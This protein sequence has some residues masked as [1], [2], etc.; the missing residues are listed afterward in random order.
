MSFLEDPNLFPL[1][2]Q[3]HR[4]HWSTH[5]SNSHR[6]QKV[7]QVLDDIAIIAPE[8]GIIRGLLQGIPF[9]TERPW[10]KPIGYHVI[11]GKSP[12][13]D[14]GNPLAWATLMGTTLY[15]IYSIYACSFKTAICSWPVLVK[16]QSTYKFFLLW[17]VWVWSFH[18][19]Y[20]LFHFLFECW[21][22]TW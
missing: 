1:W 22:P 7:P 11:C 5:N 2:S 6:Q 16:P 3:D 15:I 12:N 8:V 20:I 9:S 18:F 13:L 14:K 21:N 4:S 10:K 19:T 17:L